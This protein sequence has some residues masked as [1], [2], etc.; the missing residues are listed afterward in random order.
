MAVDPAVRE[1]MFDVITNFYNSDMKPAD[2]AKAMADGV[3][4]AK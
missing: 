2:A 1:A 3:K 4:A